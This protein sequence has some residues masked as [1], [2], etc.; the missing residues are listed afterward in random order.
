VKS[1][2]DCRSLEEIRTEIDRL[3]EQIIELLGR[4][5]TFVKAAAAF[6]TS[7]S[8]VAAPDRFAAMLQVRR[9]WAVREG[10]DPDFVERL[11]RDLVAYF[12]GR[13][14]EHWKS[15]GR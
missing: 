5:A 4:R 9:G 1:A 13:E 10:L 8:E 6:K 7:A 12:I 2:D 15:T 14:M 3:D 11:Y